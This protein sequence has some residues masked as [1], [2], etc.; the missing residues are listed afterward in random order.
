MATRPDDAFV[1]E[2][3]ETYWRAWHALRFDRQYGAM[4]GQ[5]PIT[6]VS[7]DAYARR[8]AIVDMQFE[9][10]LVLVGAMDEEYLEHVARVAEEHRQEE[11][12]KR[13]NQ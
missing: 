11:E 5:S 13:E 7:L 9:T 4:G 6:F 12:R 3:A 8:Y 2:W 10:L 1:P